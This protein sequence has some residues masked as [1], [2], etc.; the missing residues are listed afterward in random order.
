ML[1]YLHHI[2]STW[3]AVLTGTSDDCQSEVVDAIT[4][5]KLETLCPKVST[6]DAELVTDLMA[7]KSIF[8]KVRDDGDRMIIH[9]NLLESRMIPSMFTFFENLK[10]IEPC[11]QILRNLLPEEEGRSLYVALRATY[12]RPS[13]LY[14]EYAAN[15]LRLHPSS[16]TKR[17]CEIG[18]QQLWLYAL[19]NFY[20]M[21]DATPRKD[22]SSRKPKARDA[23]P[24][25]WKRLGALALSLG[26]RTEVAKRLAAQDGEERLAAQ[27]VNDAELA[28][29]ISQEATQQI[30]RI[31]RN[32]PKLQS[33]P[34]G[35]S[36]IGE[37]LLPRERRCG[38]PFESD[39]NLDRQS[40]FLPI[41]YAKPEH[42]SEHVSTLYCTLE[43]FRGFFGEENVSWQN[44]T[45]VRD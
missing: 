41:M 26:F 10:C 11:A 4:V 19:R 21:T 5:R 9:S 7:D 18:Y 22:P 45:H 43:M 14:V 31:L 3:S 40:L 34:K 2:V 30:A 20:A 33:E 6:H 36:L 44:S 17:D 38:R 42:S 39:H 37:K 23:N 15:D 16:S 25:L 1:N 35:V 12:I 8:S 27:A 32:A 28:S 24:I 29:T 13:E